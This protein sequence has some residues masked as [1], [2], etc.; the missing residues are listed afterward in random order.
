MRVA[1]S[2]VGV[3]G[4]VIATGLSALPGVQVLAFER[5]G[6]EDHAVAGNGLNV[7]P[8]ALLALD[9][10]LPALADRLR[11]VSL[12]WQ[13]WR[14]STVGGELLT[15]VPLSQVA[16]C[17]GL[18]IRWAELYRA[19]REH[20]AG[21]V[22]YRAEVEAVE[23]DPSGGPLAISVRSA[24]GQRQRLTDIDL[25][26][27]AEGRF[28]GLR[29]RL[30]GQ[31]E[32][33]YL[34]VAN[35]RVLLR[36]DGLWPLGDLEQWFNG[37]NRLLAFRLQ[38]GLVYLSGNLPIEAGQ[39]TPEHVKTA[40]WLARSYT[41]TDAPMAWVPSRLL[42][43]ACR[44]AERDELHW[45]RLQE[46]TV[47]WR[48]DSGRVLFPGDAGHA[49]VPTLGQG[50]TTAIEDGAVFVEMFHE[51]MLAGLP[52]PVLLQRFEERR[53][54]RVDF[55]RALSWQ[56]SDVIMAGGFTLSRAR[57]KG[58]APYLDKLRRLYGTA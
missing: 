22:R 31:P 17:D 1:I 44:A 32:V 58:E 52:V 38:D 46:S 19:C 9:R 24:D 49:M 23:R 16:A 4:G 54:E 37:P 18:R 47:C 40:A 36:D 27:A 26:I 7:G 29:P 3:A 21:V 2:G 14:A 12:P 28:G 8:N 30:C 53:R 25:L 51:A 20:N 34:G 42:D 15:H 33:T 57:A 5:V 35:F 6:P 11:Q 39:D 50:A 41:R 56:A 55:I 13:Q 45:S 10:T 48:D 43:G